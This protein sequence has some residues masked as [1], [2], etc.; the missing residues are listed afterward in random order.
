M[1]RPWLGRAPRVDLVVL[2]RDRPEQATLREGV[3]DLAPSLDQERYSGRARETLPWAEQRPGLTPF[4][5]LVRDDPV[6]F[7]ILDQVQL[8]LVALTPYP[9]RAVLLRSFYIDAR[10]QRRGLGR[11]AAAAVPTLARLL[12]PRA[13]QLLLTVNVDNEAARRAYLAAGFEDTGELVEGGTLGPQRI[14]RHPLVPRIASRRAD[15]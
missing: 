15:D 3:L 2:Q 14:L 7:G 6:G 1:K 11:A 8:D 4:A 10:H 12:A 9:E 13:D 5:V